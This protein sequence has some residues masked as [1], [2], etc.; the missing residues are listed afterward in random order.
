M[1]RRRVFAILIAVF[2]LMLV[3]LLV[4]SRV[5]DPSAPR[6]IPGSGN[7]IPGNYSYLQYEFLSP[8]P[9]EGGKMWVF[10]VSTNRFQAFL[11][12]IES[13]SILGELVNAYPIFFNRDQTKF[14]CTQPA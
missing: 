9:F 7:S 4:N 2:V 1:K 12:D 6:F 10:V 14:L 3:I 5:T 8:C 11:L 13:N